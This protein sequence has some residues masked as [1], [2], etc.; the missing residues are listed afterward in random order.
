MLFRSRMQLQYP[1]RTEATGYEVFPSTTE[2][3]ADV[4]RAYE[5]LGEKYVKPMNQRLAGLLATQFPGFSTA[6]K[7]LNDIEQLLASV[8]NYEGK[9][10]DRSKYFYSNVL[11]GVTPESVGRIA[12]DI[13]RTPASLLPGAADLIPSAE[14]I[15]RGYQEGP[16]AM[17]EQMAR[18]FVAGLPVSAAAAPILSNPALA[19]FAPGLL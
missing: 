17:G 14:A 13:K 15:R 7:G 4:K 19:P 5:L 2:A 10:T 1:T 9:P 6:V 3:D 11:P 16:E 18:D 8:E 12:G